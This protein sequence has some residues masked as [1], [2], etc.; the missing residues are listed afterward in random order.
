MYDV[1]QIQGT[2]NYGVFKNG[3][4]YIACLEDHDADAVLH[5][6]TEHARDVQDIGRFSRIGLDIGKLVDE[7]NAA[8]GDSFARSGQIMRILYPN[9]IAP[10]QVDDA[11]AVVRVIDK[12]FRVATDRDAL[13]E[14]PWRDVAGYGILGAARVEAARAAAKP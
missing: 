4:L 10:E 9:G 13:G 14:S 12:L 3:D 5:H 11:L 2:K 6:L 1:R 7:K 8:Y